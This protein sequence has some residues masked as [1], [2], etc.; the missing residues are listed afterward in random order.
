MSRLSSRAQTFE[1]VKESRLERCAIWFARDGEKLIGRDAAVARIL[2]HRA[3][4]VTQCVRERTRALGDVTF[5][6]KIIDVAHA[7]DDRSAVKVAAIF[8]R[9]I[10]QRFLAIRAV[11]RRARETHP[12]VNPKPKRIVAE[13]SVAHV[14]HDRLAQRTQT[15][16]VRAAAREDVLNI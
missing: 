16:R 14:E 4:A 3:N 9:E 15:D 7:R 10:I 13:V 5:L 2:D 11:Q 6:K 12:Y 8:A 1:I